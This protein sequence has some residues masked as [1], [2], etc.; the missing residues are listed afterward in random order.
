MEKVDVSLEKILYEYEKYM[1][2]VLINKYYDLDILRNLVSDFSKQSDLIEYCDNDS[3]NE[4]LKKVGNVI[5]KLE[6]I[7][8]N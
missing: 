7:D 2:S 1:M 8:Y 3:D 4:L 5:K 6:K